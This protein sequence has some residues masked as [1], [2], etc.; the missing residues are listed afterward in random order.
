MCHPETWGQGRGGCSWLPADLAALEDAQRADHHGDEGQ[1]EH[2]Q[3]DHEGKEV[4]GEVA[5]DEEEDQ[6]VDVVCGDDRA[7]PLDA[8]TGC[9]INQ[10]LLHLQD[11]MDRVLQNLGERKRQ[12]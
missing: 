1:V 9:P 10:V 11:G 12:K 8:G 7:E 2:Q 5:D 4:D 6:R 3:G